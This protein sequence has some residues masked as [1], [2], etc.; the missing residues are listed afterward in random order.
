[1]A[2]WHVVGK[3]NKYISYVLVLLAFSVKTRGGKRLSNYNDH[4]SPWM[5]RKF[6][7]LLYNLEIILYFTF[8]H[9]E[10]RW[11]SNGNWKVLRRFQSQSKNKSL[12]SWCQKRYYLLLTYLLP[13]SRRA[14]VVW[15]KKDLE[16]LLQAS[17]VLK[18]NSSV[19][20]ASTGKRDVR[21]RTT[22]LL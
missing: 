14:A 5:E 18:N 19:W 12:Q 20:T 17:T 3:V 4:L 7:W 9:V 16:R 6:L 8:E 21:S 22:T 2:W 1:M 10:C 15:W 13:P 11:W